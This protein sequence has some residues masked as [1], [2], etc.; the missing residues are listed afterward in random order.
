MRGRRATAGRGAKL[1]LVARLLGVTYD[2]LRQRGLEEARRRA[3]ISQ[4]VATAMG[5]L[6]RDAI[7]LTAFQRYAAA[8]AQL[9][10]AA[11]RTSPGRPGA[12]AAPPS[13]ACSLAT[14]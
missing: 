3:H 7:P 5:L 1:K 11:G 13:R 6:A 2:A 12:T 4:A 9:R 14:A 10:R 8:A